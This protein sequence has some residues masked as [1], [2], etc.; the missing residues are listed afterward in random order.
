M[1][2][3]EHQEVVYLVCWFDDG[4]VGSKELRLFRFI[5]YLINT[6]IILD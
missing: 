3:L 6:L 2:D 4:L 1:E 5:M